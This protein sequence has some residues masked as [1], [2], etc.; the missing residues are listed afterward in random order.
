MSNRDPKF[1]HTSSSH[2]YAFSN[3]HA[4]QGTALADKPHT[5]TDHSHLDFTPPPDRS[6][7]RPFV[8]ALKSWGN[9]SV[10]CLPLHEMGVADPQRKV[11][12]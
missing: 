5:H 11:M 8:L 6:A 4:H 12:W 2:S 10:T 1:S 3:Q 7:A 9:M